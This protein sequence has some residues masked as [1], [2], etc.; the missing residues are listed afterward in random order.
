MRRVPWW[1]A[2][3]E[4][5]EHMPTNGLMRGRRSEWRFGLGLLCLSLVAGCGSGL[6]GL[7][8]DTD[9]DGVTD[10]ME[11]RLGLSPLAA[12]TDGDGL[13]DGAEL[14]AGTSPLTVDS[15][16]DGLSD[17]D[18]TT[19]GAGTIEPLAVS[20][21]NDVEPNDAFTSAVALANSGLAD[22]S[23]EGRIE[24]S[25]DVDVFELG[26][27]APGDR[28]VVDMERRDELLRPAIVL[29]DQAGQ[30]IAANRDPY[31]QGAPTCRGLS[32]L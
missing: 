16:R 20:S 11:A 5:G 13:T 27:L 15:D 23:F 19:R 22:L 17:A 24:P 2:K 10:S 8:I 14:T 28:V 9:G 7:S 32:T 18:D 3:R 6:A 1:V 12:D 30:V 31:T 25:C 21:G 29:F 26:S 4:G